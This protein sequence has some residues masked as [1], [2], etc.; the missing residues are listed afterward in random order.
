MMGFFLN[1]YFK[2]DHKLTGNI[3]QLFSKIEL[4]VIFWAEET[5]GDM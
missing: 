3:F 4:F 2:T 5:Q 1:G